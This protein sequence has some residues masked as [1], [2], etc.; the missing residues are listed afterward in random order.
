MSI[1]NAFYSDAI[2]F[3][4]FLAEI[5]ANCE[6]PEKDMIALKGSMDLDGAKVRTLF[7]RAQKAFERNK[8]WIC[9]APN[10]KPGKAFIQTLQSMVEEMQFML[11]FAGLA[12]W[13]F[14][15]SEKNQLEMI[16]EELG[17]VGS[18]IREFI[19]PCGE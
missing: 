3:P 2:Q 1:K 7:S 19:E 6:I 16:Y 14:S 12:P 13:R 8:G 15:D 17:T 4:R 10:D 5:A 9:P 18:D 11:D